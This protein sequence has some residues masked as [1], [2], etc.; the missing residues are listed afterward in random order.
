MS[1]PLASTIQLEQEGEPFPLKRGVR[2]GD[3]ISAKLFISCLQH[4]V[5]NLNAK[6]S[7]GDYGIKIR[8]KTINDLHFAD[9]IILGPSELQQMLE[10]L[11]SMSKQIGLKMNK[12]KTKVRIN[13][14]L[15]PTLN[16]QVEGQKIEP[17]QSYLYLGQPELEIKT[18]I[19]IAWCRFRKLGRPKTQNSPS[20]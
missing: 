11:H 12:P 7:T 8:N 18:R 20:V 5:Q 19:S 9:E 2:Q 4:V 15:T 3:T 16:I 6:W 1:V 10:D 17:V 14:R 13:N